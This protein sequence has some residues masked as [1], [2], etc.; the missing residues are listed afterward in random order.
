MH[1]HKV[2]RICHF[3]FSLAR[4]SSNLVSVSVSPPVA[5]ANLA[6]KAFKL[7]LL[8]RPKAFDSLAHLRAEAET[9]CRSGW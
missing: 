1:A 9:A 6:L 4:T 2:M 3:P 7:Q 8:E 5:Q